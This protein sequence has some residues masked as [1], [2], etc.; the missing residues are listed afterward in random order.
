MIFDYAM[1]SMLVKQ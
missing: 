1:T